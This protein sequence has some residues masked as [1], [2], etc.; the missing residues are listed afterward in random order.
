[1]PLNAVYRKR[2]GPVITEGAEVMDRLVTQLVA[3][4]KE[5]TSPLPVTWPLTCITASG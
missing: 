3:Q 4:R 2:I 1:M 5:A